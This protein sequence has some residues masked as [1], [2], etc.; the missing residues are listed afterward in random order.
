MRR[1]LFAALLFSLPSAAFAAGD[2]PLASCKGWNGTIIEREG[3]DTQH[4]TMSG[5]LT[6]AD[7]QEYCERDP[8][9]E[10]QQ[11]GGKLTLKQCVKRYMQQS[12]KDKMSSTANCDTGQLSFKLSQKPAQRVRFPLQD[13]DTSCASGMPPLIE[14]FKLLCPKAAERWG[15]Q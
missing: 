8:G 14:Q 5:I 13:E 12:G 7:F 6:K 4:A 3:I 1:Q 10:T 15:V 9:G 11:Y 2:F